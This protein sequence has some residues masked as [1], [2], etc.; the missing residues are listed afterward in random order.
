MI[1]Q[2]QLP[3]QTC[4]GCG[5]CGAACPVQAIRMETDA[6]GFAYPAIDPQLCIRCGRCMQICA[7]GEPEPAGQP[8][9]RWAAVSRNRAT[10]ENCSSGGVFGELAQAAIHKG[11][12]VF[13]AA[14]DGWGN[15][16]H[17][18]VQQVQELS[19]LYG[20][21]YAQSD[22]TQ[23]WEQL[24]SALAEKP[25]VLVCATPCQI[26]AVRRKYGNREN[27]YLVDFLCHGVASP[28]VFRSYVKARLRD[29]E[30]DVISFRDK[31]ISA[32]AYSMLLRSGKQVYRRYHQD[33]LFMRGYLQNLYLRQSCYQCSFTASRADLTLGDFFS[34]TKHID[35]E[36]GVSQVI[37]N[38]DKGKKL[39]KQIAPALE[40]EQIAPASR[41]HAVSGN[42]R[43]A[44]FFADMRSRGILAALRKN[45]TKPA[46]KVWLYRRLKYGRR[47]RR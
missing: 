25:S 10:C 20:S 43:R 3:R 30:A 31:T 19:S 37:V 16:F 26:A 41:S 36:Q 23:L 14:V 34:G 24:D 1:K 32:K 29:R 12:S 46:F 47:H 42:D 22:L 6:E 5:A 8:L 13:G 7:A 38:T 27:L 35:P 45:T 17:R 15:V 9:E 2:I 40:A 44:Q 33:D 39:L 21:K 18:Q 4:T 11:G 28:E